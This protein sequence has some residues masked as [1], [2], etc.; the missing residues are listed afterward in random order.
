MQQ[1]TF[2]QKE[3]EKMNEYEAGQL[4]FEQK[5]V[6][7]LFLSASKM[8]FSILDEPKRDVFFPL[9]SLPG[10]HVRLLPNGASAGT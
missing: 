2:E 9:M 3:Q 7:T 5:G 8:H 4:L 10:A 1:E 6:K